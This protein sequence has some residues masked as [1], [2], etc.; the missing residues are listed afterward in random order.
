MNTKEN[1]VVGCLVY[2]SLVLSVP[3][4]QCEETDWRGEGRVTL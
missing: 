3:S 4:I 1:A 2:P